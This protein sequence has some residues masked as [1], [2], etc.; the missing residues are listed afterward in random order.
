MGRWDWS[1][2]G[3]EVSM[4]CAEP[5]VAP[6]RILL[7]ASLDAARRAAVAALIGVPVALLREPLVAP[8]SSSLLGVIHSLTHLERWWFAHT[9]AGL[10]VA[11]EPLGRHRRDRWS[12]GRS[13]TAWT[14][15]AEYRAECRRSRHI[16]EHAALDDVSARAAPDGQRVVL[17]WVLLRMI[18]ETNRHTG[19]AE[20]LRHLIDGATTPAS[21]FK[22]PNLRPVRLVREPSGR[23]HEAGRCGVRIATTEIFVDDQD[24]ALRF[25]TDVLG[26]TLQM[27]APYGDTGRWL[28]V[29]S[30]EQPDGPALLLAPLTDA[31]RA[32]QA[33]RGRAGSPAISLDTD[34]CQG[35]FARLCDSGVEFVSPPKE[36]AYGGVDAV[37]RDGCGNLINLHQR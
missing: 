4:G 24:E 7:S 8:D 21:S 27:D 9:F 1:I 6:E 31:A 32:L 18:E 22:R 34:D 13:D 19:E 29:V 25:Y 20:V 15:L 28:T 10:D 11:I 14:V 12:L 33:A 30:P 35:T 26:F 17:R 3:R 36:M 23:R 16:T 2:I 5:D 37:F